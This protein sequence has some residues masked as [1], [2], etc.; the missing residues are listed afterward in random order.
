MG[1]E[2]QNTTDVN[3]AACKRGADEGDQDMGDQDMGAHVGRAWTPACKQP[4]VGPEATRAAGDNQNICNQ[5]K[6]VLHSMA[7]CFV[8]A[9]RGALLLSYTPFAKQSCGNVLSV[10]PLANR[11][12]AVALR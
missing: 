12:R 10:L 11:C 2:D 8:S 7:A 5:L 3:G 1:A 6:K 9:G 4:G